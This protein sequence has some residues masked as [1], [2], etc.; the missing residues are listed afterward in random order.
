MPSTTAGLAAATAGAESTRSAATATA[1]ISLA[2]PTAGSTPRVPRPGTPPTSRIPS[3]STNTGLYVNGTMWVT[4][5]KTGYVTDAALNDGPEPLETGDVVV[6]TGAAE[7]LAGEIPVIRVR[8]ATAADST[9]VAG[10]VDQGVA[11]QKGA[12]D[13]QAI[14]G[15]VGHEA[16]VAD[17][18]AI[19]PGRISADRHAGRLQRRQGRRDERRRST[20]ATCS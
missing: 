18:T 11:M 10:V 2:A 13:E 7:P 4:G 5:A 12:Q 9:A 15:V 1:A 3:G 19:K 14:P 16:H 6:I 20:Q 17:N 8:K